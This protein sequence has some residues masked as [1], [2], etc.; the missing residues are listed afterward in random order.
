[1]CNVKNTAHCNYLLGDNPD[2]ILVLASVENLA[3]K[4]II[5][6]K[7]PKPHVHGFCCKVVQEVG[8]P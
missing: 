6:S 8:P 4:V 1:M 2:H 3:F 7:V 5:N